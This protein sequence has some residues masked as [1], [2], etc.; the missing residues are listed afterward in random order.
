MCPCHHAVANHPAGATRRVIRFA[1]GRAAFALT[2]AG[3]ASGTSPFRGHHTF[4]SVTA[5]RLAPIPGMGS[6][7]GFRSIGFPPACPPATG[8]PTLTPAGLTPAE[9]I[10]LTWTH[11]RTCQF[12]GIRLKPLQTPLAGHGLLH[13]QSL[14]VNLPV[15][16]G[17]QQDPIVHRVGAAVRSPEKVMD[18]PTLLKR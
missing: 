4:T 10:S 18:V 15:T 7:R 5:W 9:H 8:L 1:T 13:H 12:P 2:V 6:S 17:M 16:V 3:S 11:N 14:T